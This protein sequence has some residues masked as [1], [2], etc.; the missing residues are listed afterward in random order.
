MNHVVPGKEAKKTRLQA[1]IERLRK[2]LTNHK[3]SHNC[4]GKDVSE[5]V[6]ASFKSHDKTQHEELKRME[7]KAIG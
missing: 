7:E 2:H 1:A 5:E 6:L 3:K 4:D